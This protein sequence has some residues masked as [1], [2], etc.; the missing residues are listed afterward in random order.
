VSPA[1]HWPLRINAFGI[2]FLMIAAITLRTRMASLRLRTELAPP[3][4]P[5]AAAGEGSR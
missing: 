3:P 2:L 1:F 5:A 4:P